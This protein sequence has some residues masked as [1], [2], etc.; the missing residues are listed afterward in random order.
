MDTYSIPQKENIEQLYNDL[1]CMG[2]FKTK[3]E[4]FS[5]ILILHNEV[6]VIFNEL[7]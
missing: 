2:V 6:C 5:L 4:L 1:L 7:E 3:E